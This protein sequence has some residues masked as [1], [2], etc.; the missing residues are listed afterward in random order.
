[1]DG[2]H[3]SIVEFFMCLLFTALFEKLDPNSI[4]YSLS[5]NDWS[6]EVFGSIHPKLKSGWLKR[7]GRKSGFDSM[8]TLLEEKK[9]TV[10]AFLKNLGQYLDDMADDKNL[11]SLSSSLDT[12]LSK[13]KNDLH[14]MKSTRSKVLKPKINLK[15][16]SNRYD[17]LDDEFDEDIA[18][19]SME[20]SFSTESNSRDPTEVVMTINF[21]HVSCHGIITDNE[22][23]V[24]EEVDAQLSSEKCDDEYDW[25]LISCSDMDDFEEVQYSF[26]DALARSEKAPSQ[27]DSF[28]FVDNV[29]SDDEC[30]I[31]ID[32][33]LELQL[34]QDSDFD[35]S[36][37]KHISKGR[38]Y[39]NDRSKRD[40]M[41]KVSKRTN[42]LVQK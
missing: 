8:A 2:G 16:Y 33:G 9:Y 13:A 31:D 25:D 3:E 24:E 26:K 28:I 27:P 7:L 12:V 4:H 11:L 19:S 30:T 20:D 18:S 17:V 23:E 5:L 40:Y 35:R 38:F 37:Y 1:M 21:D 36:G 14:Y 6:T 39:K 10:N 29:I 41:R 22:I 42:V 34:E 32:R 15:E